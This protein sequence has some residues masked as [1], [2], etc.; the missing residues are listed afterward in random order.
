MK[1]APAVQTP[2]ASDQPAPKREIHWGWTLYGAS[3][4]L[5]SL[6]CIALES[7]RNFI[8]G[9]K[10][11]SDPLH[12]FITGST[13]A[14]AAMMLLIVQVIAQRSGWST[15]RLLFYALC[16][17]VTGYCGLDYYSGDIR[18][19]VREATQSTAKVDGAR[20]DLAD[21]IRERDDAQDDQRRAQKIADGFA[22]N[23]PAQTLQGLA[24]K[25]DQLARDETTDE[26]RGKKCGDICRAAERERDGYLKRIPD[27]KAKEEAQRRADDARDRAAKARDRIAAARPTAHLGPVEAS[28]MAETVGGILSINTV[29]YANWEGIALP[30]ALVVLPLFGAGLWGEGFGRLMHGL[31]F[32]R[33]ESAEA[34]PKGLEVVAPPDKGAK[35][36]SIETAKHRR[37]PP[38]TIEAKVIEVVKKIAPKKLT[39]R[40]RQIALA[41]EI[42]IRSDAAGMSAADVLKHYV[43]EHVKRLADV[44][45]PKKNAVSQVMEDAGFT[46]DR[47]S[48]PTRYHVALR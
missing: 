34:Q 44:P 45:V 27:A 3:V 16:M 38:A 30:V 17:A 36:I 32:D 5:V 8:F 9:I 1:P 11:T 41:Q 20:S 19:R 21:A 48:G 10:S 25:A 14:L 12:A 47:K 39:E 46:K 23:T 37:K 22:E 35:V 7:G 33:A 6:Y 28:S 26:K 31:G 40:E 43:D 42:F 13:L 15:R 4:C 29:T 2:K 18:A 24:D